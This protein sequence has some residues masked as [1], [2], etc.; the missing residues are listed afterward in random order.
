[1]DELSTSAEP[2]PVLPNQCGT[3][4]SNS[5]ASPSVQ[6]EVLSA[7][8]QPHPCRPGR[9]ATR[10]RRGA[11]DGYGVDRPRGD[12]DLPGA[13]RRSAGAVSGRTVRPCRPATASRRVRG[14]TT[15]GRDDR[16]GRRAGR[17]CGRPVPGVYGG[18]SSTLLGTVAG[19][20]EVRDGVLFVD[21]HEDTMPVDVPRTARRPT[22]S[23][24]AARVPGG[25]SG[26]LAARG[27]R[28]GDRLAVLGPRDDA[29]RISRGNAAERVSGSRD[30]RRRQR[31]RGQAQRRRPPT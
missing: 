20:R 10:T 4:V 21:G 24:A 6:H 12:D 9:T 5:A 27:R 15:G 16:R 14:S 19:V 13:G 1:M 22:P 18:D 31:P 23:R 25:C 2:S 7:E 11:V 29:W 26:P 8:H 17:R 28:G 3:W 30:C